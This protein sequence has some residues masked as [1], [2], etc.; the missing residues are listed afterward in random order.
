MSA[1]SSGVIPAVSSD[2][3]FTTSS[4]VI[5]AI[6]S[7]VTS[8]TS[9][10][11]L[12]NIVNIDCKK[13]SESESAA[14]DFH[15]KKVSA[16][17]VESNIL[18]EI[19]KLPLPFQHLLIKEACAIMNRLEKSKGV[20]GLISLDCYCLF[21]NRYLLLCKHIFYGNNLLTADVWKRFQEMFKESRFEV[22]ESRESFVVYVQSEQQRG[23]KN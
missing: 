3:T 4:G 2:I 6:F 10:D 14:L 8:T 5:P 22:Y 17:G 21:R 12:H 13:R 20:P 1:T 18:E 16:Y 15:I 11:A 19:H 23:A 7:D 9:S